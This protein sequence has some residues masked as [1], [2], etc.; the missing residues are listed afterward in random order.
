MVADYLLSRMRNGLE[1]T[2]VPSSIRKPAVILIAMLL[3]VLGLAPAAAYHE[4]DD[5]EHGFANDAFYDR[6][7]RTDLPVDQNVVDRTW[8]W[9][10]EPYTEGMTEPYAES[11]GGER[12][13][14][15][16]D[17]SRM[18][19]TYPNRPDDGLWYV[20]NG[21]LVV[22]MVNGRI[23]V[24]DDEFVDAQPADIPIAGDPDSEFGPTYA[25][26]NDYGLRGEPA[27]NVGTVLDMTLDN[28]QVVQD[29]GYAE[30]GITAGHRV[31]VPGIDHT[32]AS[33]FWDFMNSSGTVFEDGNYFEADLFVNPFYAT[34]YPIT[35]AYWATVS[36]GGTERDVL[37]QCFERRCL[38]Y[39]PG[40]PEGFL[41]EAGNVGQHY[42][43]WRYGQVTPPPAT[44][45]VT[46]Y[47]VQPGE[48][49]EPTDNGDG[50]FGCMDTLVPV[51]VEIDAQE[52]DE[53]RITAALNMLFGYEHDELYNVFANSNL[54]VQDV[55]IENGVATVNLSGELSIGGVCDEPR[56]TE[57]LNATITQFAGVNSANVLLNGSPILEE[58]AAETVNIYLVDVG[59]GTDP[60]NDLAFGCDD[61]LVPVEVEISS[62][63][64]LEARVQAAVNA[65]FGY[66]HDTLYNV[67]A[68]LGDMSVAD[69][70][71]VNGV[72]TINIS[73]DLMVGGVCDEPRVIEQVAATATQ[74]EGVDRAV[75]LINGGNP[76]PS[77]AIEAEL[78]GGVLA[79]FDVAGEQ[80]NLWTTNEDTIND[81]MALQDNPDLSLHPN[82]PILYGPGEADHNAP[83]GWHLDPQQTQ[84]VEVSIEVCDGRPS[85][86]EGETEE[87][88]ENIGNYC[89]WGAELV[90]VQD[91]R[92]DS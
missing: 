59:A 27:A 9:G 39:T 79:T 68:D 85:Y 2:M 55:T 13:V 19:L 34:G 16:F 3:A 62:Q 8:M 37:W 47:L 88:V 23:Q 29:A 53:G 80:F 58:P 18:E 63:G 77:Q 4:G 33:V 75:V 35:E 1:G 52:N 12:L 5:A 40:N 89:P 81:I 11:P 56:V 83:W 28:G 71:I 7:A 82:G 31:T 44:E 17:K 61:L 91:F 45:T 46:I 24:G 90:N 76:F 21:L 10:P 32:V 60:E 36:V 26:I 38:T 49:E 20:T 15:Y 30:Y 69:V 22:E 78:E 25:D 42:Y 87:F 50:T 67:Y 72:A 73:G 84:M 74:F 92:N 41:V 86:V 64:S 14:Q 48:G 70:Q 66:E 65:L 57:Q 43:N 51:E 6:W 54:T